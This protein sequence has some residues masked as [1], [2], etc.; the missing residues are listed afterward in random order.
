[1]ENYHDISRLRM[2]MVICMCGDMRSL[3]HHVH[4]SP[5]LAIR[6]ST[7]LVPSFS[8]DINAIVPYTLVQSRIGTGI[9]SLNVRQLGTSFQ[10]SRR[11]TAQIRHVI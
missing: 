1:M 3:G 11:A 7:R 4:D 6:E 5:R 10:L 8:K 2:H 9:A